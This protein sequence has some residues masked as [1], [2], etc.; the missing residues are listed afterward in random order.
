MIR[1][2]LT[3]IVQ[4]FALA[5]GMCVPGAV[6]GQQGSG[7]S[8]DLED[9]GS[10]P[11]VSEWYFCVRQLD[12]QPT[13][14]PTQ[15][16]KCLKQILAHRYFKSGRIEVS[17]AASSSQR[18]VFVLNSPK[19]KITNIEYGIR[20][21]FEGDFQEYLAANN[22][23]PRV[24]EIYEY[25]DEGGN[26]SRIQNFFASKRIMVG[27]SKKISLNY[28]SGTAT[29]TYKE[30]EGPEGPKR[31]FAADCE[32][33]ITNF[34]LLDLDDFTPLGLILR[35][36]RTRESTCYSDSITKTDE[37]TLRNMK[38][39]SDVH[40]SVEGNGSTRTVFLNARTN[41]LL[42]SSVSIRGY[43][44]TSTSEIQRQSNEMPML[45]TKPSQVYRYSDAVI[46]RKL[47]EAYFRTDVARA[48]VFE[49]DDLQT[50]STL[51]VTFHVL[52]W[53]KDELY[54]DGHQLEP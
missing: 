49:T 39:F 45:H 10:I 23:F 47:L 50:D 22:E 17:Q 11:P 48:E 25:L 3:F 16:E 44:S 37:Q 41:P 43:G 46:S 5:L 18:V 9:H 2:R 24:G 26:E 51:K 35:A 1:Q 34:N 32:V 40:Y 53:P 21:D 4:I 52:T 29:L 20:K 42:V 14:N 36:T 7:I 13:Y 27:V 31:F 12:D 28:R 19:L 15:G 38:I 8:V 30:W 6:R 54:I 33:R